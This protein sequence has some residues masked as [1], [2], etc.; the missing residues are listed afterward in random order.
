MLTISSAIS[1]AAMP[2]QLSFRYF[3]NSLEIIQLARKIQINP[4]HLNAS[5]V[6]A[7]RTEST[8]GWLQPTAIV[9]T[10]IYTENKTEKATRQLR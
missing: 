3:K 8:V 10:E 2:N 1:Y 6:Q 5:D 9:F 4:Y 7:R